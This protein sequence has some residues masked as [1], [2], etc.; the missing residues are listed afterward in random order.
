MVLT[1]LWIPLFIGLLLPALSK[2][3]SSA[4][5][6]QEMSRLSEIH[7]SMLLY[8]TDNEKNQTPM[9]DDVQKMIGKK[10]AWGNAYRIDEEGP[11]VPKISSAG[12]DG[13]HDTEDDIHST[14]LDTQAP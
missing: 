11:E 2:A 9:S 5:R 4:V 3:R 10:D 14:D 1:L 6:A 7:R 12:P 13:V 8:S